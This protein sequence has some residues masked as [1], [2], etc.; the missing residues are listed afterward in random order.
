LKSG[1]FEERLARYGHLLSAGDP[2]MANQLNMAKVN[3]ILTLYERGW[4]Y[5]RIGRELGIRRET[6]WRHVRLA[7]DGAKPARAP[8]GSM[9]AEADRDL[10]S[11]PQPSPEANTAIT[12]NLLD[13]DIE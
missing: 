5:R 12:F 1:H 9:S 7:A 10:R 13:L 8:A 2:T 6:V 4:S 11:L 3:A